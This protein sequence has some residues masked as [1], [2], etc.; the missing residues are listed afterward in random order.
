MEL[1]K[2]ED[3]IDTAFAKQLNHLVNSLGN[4]R[5]KGKFHYK[6]KAID[7]LEKILKNVKKEI[8]KEVDI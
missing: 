8:R 5:E 1:E 7:K 4:T 3:I 6:M 2:I